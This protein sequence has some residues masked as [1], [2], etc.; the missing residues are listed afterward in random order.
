MDSPPSCSLRRVEQIP[1]L[2][3][4]RYHRNVRRRGEARSLRAEKQIECF[5]C[6]G[7]KENYKRTLEAAAAQ[8]TARGVEHADEGDAT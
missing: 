2:K 6:H 4:E 3:R 5:Q 7:K 1:Q 8:A